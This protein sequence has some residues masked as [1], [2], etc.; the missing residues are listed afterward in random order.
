M[1]YTRDFLDEHIKKLGWTVGEHSYGNPEVHAWGHDAG[2]FIGRYCS[3][4]PR[5][6]I[7]LGGNHR[8][9]WVTTYPF[10]A[11]SDWAAHVTGHPH[12]KGD[13]VIGNDVWLG[14]NCLILSGVTIGDGACVAADA[15]V[16]KNV[17]P[18]TIVGGNP[19]RLIRKRFTDSQIYRL[20]EI[21][22]WD[23]PEDRIREEIEQLMSGNV[24]QFIASATGNRLMA[25]D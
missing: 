23:W 1:F 6:R 19:A 17:E 22:W 5:V 11:L 3:I 25:T 20:L 8:T 16:T 14:A 2:L 18:Y 4:A 21:A 13:V 10:S 24:D 9:D 7:F 15:V 12:T